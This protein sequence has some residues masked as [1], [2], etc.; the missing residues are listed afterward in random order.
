[1]CIRI[2]FLNVILGE[3][4]WYWRVIPNL[5]LII[6]HASTGTCKDSY[7]SEVCTQRCSV[8][9][10]KL[11]SLCAVS[12]TNIVK[13]NVLCMAGAGSFHLGSDFPGFVQFGKW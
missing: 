8:R 2:K 4:R 7:F 1:M 13:P 9:R 10:Q 6:Q 3:E 12:Q 11:K 5:T